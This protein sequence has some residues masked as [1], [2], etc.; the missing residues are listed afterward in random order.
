MPCEAPARTP[1][2]DAR[3]RRHDNDNKAPILSVLTG[4]CPDRGIKELKQNLVGHRSG[5]KRRS[6]QVV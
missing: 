1:P 5:L 4:R 6:E 3:L 2:L